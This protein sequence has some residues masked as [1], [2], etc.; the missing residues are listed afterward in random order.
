MEMYYTEKNQNDIDF[1][2]QLIEICITIGHY[3]KSLDYFYVIKNNHFLL[4]IQK[5]KGC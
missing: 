2:N 5:Q 3:E 1:Y 4:Q